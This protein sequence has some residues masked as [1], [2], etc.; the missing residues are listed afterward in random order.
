MG[1]SYVQL[2]STA[3]AGLVT[4]G[5]ILRRLGPADF[6]VFALITG[7]SGFVNSLGLS[8]GLSVVRASAQQRS[9]PESEQ[10]GAMRDVTAA[11]GVYVAFGAVALAVMAAVAFFIPGLLGATHASRGAVEAT[12]LLIGLSTGLSLATS[13]LTG[14]AGG[15]RDFRALAIAAA[16]GS[17]ASIAV[18]V[19][20]VDRL[21]LV[22]LGWSELASVACNSGMLWI[23]ARRHARWFRLRPHRL[24]TVEVGRVIRSAIP[25][26]LLNLGGQVIATTDLFVLGGFYSPTVVG[27]YKL[28]SLLPTQAISVL[29]Q[30]YDVALPSLVGAN[31]ERSQE[32]T[33]AFLTRIG[34]YVGGAGLATVALLR[35]DL[36]LLLNGRASHLAASVILV[37]CGIWMTTLVAHGIGL[38]LIAR[39][40]QRK[41]TW[42]VVGEIVLNLALT[43][44]L[45]PTIGAIGAAMAT[46]VTLALSHLVVLPFIARGELAIRTGR[47]LAVDGWLSI[48]IGCA[49]AGAAWLPVATAAP[50]LTRLLAGGAITGIFSAAVGGLLLRTG[51]RR[52]LGALMRMAPGSGSC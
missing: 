34:C 41:F 3:L 16:S 50:S 40:R 37:F 47:L 31:D 42:P 11:H 35:N 39:G 8:L 44:I 2:G 20:L 13:A 43:I 30:G 29:Y 51:G 23:W 18:V 22:T 49:V 6:G 12:G 5:L 26:V 10:A 45:V 32:E 1:W 19:G 36:V 38:L 48:G 9:G 4:A 25:L 21:G 52:R 27:L 24:T 7:V 14:L 33:V 17:V 46:L 15:C 28:G